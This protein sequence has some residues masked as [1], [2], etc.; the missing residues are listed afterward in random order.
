MAGGTVMRL[1][2]LVP[3]QIVGDRDRF[4]V[5]DQEAVIRA[6]ERRPTAHPRRRTGA[7]QVDRRPAAEIVMPAV[8]WEMPLMAAPAELGRLRTLADKPVDRPAVDEFP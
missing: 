5:G 3:G 8:G 1:A 2:A 6:F 7:Q 4:A